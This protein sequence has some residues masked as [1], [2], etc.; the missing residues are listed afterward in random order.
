MLGLLGQRILVV[1][2]KNIVIVRLGK[3]RDKRQTDK[4][5]LDIDNYYYVDEVTAMTESAK[6]VY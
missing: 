4:G 5:A 2:E 1:P 6:T 3:S